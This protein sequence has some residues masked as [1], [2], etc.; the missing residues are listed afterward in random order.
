[1]NVG[2]DQFVIR[3]RVVAGQHEVLILLASHDGDPV[4]AAAELLRAL[5]AHHALLT[6]TVGAGQGD[7]LVHRSP[8][9]RQASR[10]A[11]RLRSMT[12]R[13]RYFGVRRSR[14]IV[15]RCFMSP[16]LGASARDC[17]YP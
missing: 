8:P 14:W 10:A 4:I 6:A 3:D 5:E 7:V 2:G 17:A 11:L 1:M 9:R 12:M 15:L 16:S 13:L